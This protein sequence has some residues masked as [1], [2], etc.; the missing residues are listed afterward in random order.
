MDQVKSEEDK[1]GREMGRR[2][3]REERE[4]GWGEGGGE[5]REGGVDVE[6]EGWVAGWTEARC[7]SVDGRERRGWGGR[8]VSSHEGP[9]PSFELGVVSLAS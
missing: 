9:G 4:Q 5:T 7:Q 8:R 2:S 6:M 1:L 3:L